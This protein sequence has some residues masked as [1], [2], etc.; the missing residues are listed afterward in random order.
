V[1]FFIAAEPYIA[2]GSVSEGAA[3]NQYDWHCYLDDPVNGTA[4]DMIIA[5]AELKAAIA[6]RRHRPVSFFDR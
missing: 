5:E 3:P 4:R 1:N 6:S 2:V